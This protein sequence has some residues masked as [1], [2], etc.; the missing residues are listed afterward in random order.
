MS[1]TPHLTAGAL[2]GAGTAGGQRL[3]SRDGTGSAGSTGQ[4]REAW[5]GPAGVP[6]SS[7]D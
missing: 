7:A 4:G 1:K 5:A 2:G 6:V 3:T